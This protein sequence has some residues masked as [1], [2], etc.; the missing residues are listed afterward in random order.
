V[1]EW[2]AGRFVLL[3]LPQP[4]GVSISSGVVGSI[5]GANMLVAAVADPRPGLRW[6]CILGLASGALMAVLSAASFWALRIQ[7]RR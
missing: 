5:V 6:W 2:K 4:L 1:W 3:R 7:R